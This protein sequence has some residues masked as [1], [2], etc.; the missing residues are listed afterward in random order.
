[1][2]R[3]GELELEGLIVS[4]QTIFQYLSI[5]AQPYSFQGVFNIL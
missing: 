1:M 2:T 3:E 5:I 4:P